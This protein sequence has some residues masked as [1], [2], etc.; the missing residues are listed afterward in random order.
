MILANS[1]TKVWGDLMAYAAWST[2][3]R[4]IRSTWSPT[5]NMVSTTGC[6]IPEELA[7]TSPSSFFRNSCCMSLEFSKL[8]FRKYGKSTEWFLFSCLLSMLRIKKLLCAD[9]KNSKPLQINFSVTLLARG[10]KVTQNNSD[11]SE[12]TI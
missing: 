3:P 12:N 10:D 5:P 7:A 9:L 4:S 1:S 6:Q 11:K 2:C 8:K